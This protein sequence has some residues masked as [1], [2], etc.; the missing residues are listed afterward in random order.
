MYLIRGAYFDSAWRRE[1]GAADTLWTSQLPARAVSGTRVLEFVRRLSVS[2]GAYRVAWSMQDEHARVRA[3]ARADADASRFAG[4]Q[5]ALSDVLLYDEA[6]PGQRSGLVE[7]GGMRM[8][9]R[10]GHAFTSADP[11]HSYVEVYGLNLL[12]SASDYQVRYSIYPATNNDTPVW[13]AIAQVAA[14][15]LGFENDEPVISQTFTR[16]AT[17]HTANERIAI[18][19]GTLEPGYYELLVEVMDLNS[20]QRA[21]SHTPIT[22]EPGPMGRR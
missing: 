12:D 13:R 3:L 8:L 4:D 1:G 2:F 19:I 20:G 11:L 14:D 7:R 17:E 9:P 16:H 6:G 21:A 22:V 18:D 10:I 15:V 5:L